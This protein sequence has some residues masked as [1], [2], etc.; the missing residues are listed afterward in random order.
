MIGDPESFEW[1]AMPE[2]VAAQ[3]MAAPAWEWALVEIFGHRQH[4]GRC[5]E[6]ERFGAKMLRVDVPN[7]GKPDEHGWTTHFYGGSA[8]FSFTLTDEQSV[9]EANKPYEAA[10]RYRLPAPDEDNPLED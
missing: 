9:M 2:A 6:E 10:G 3:P 8:I 4:A 5:R 7:Q 1:E